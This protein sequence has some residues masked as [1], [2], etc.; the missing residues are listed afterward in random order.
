MIVGR[1][2]IHQEFSALNGAGVV[3]AL[4]IY[5]K[6]VAILSE[7]LPDDDQIAVGIERHVR[8]ALSAGGGSIYRQF[9]ADGRA[10]GVE[11]LGDDLELTIPD[12]GELTDIVHVHPG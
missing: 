7:A 4:A 6:A 1:G 5:A 3:V 2:R 9:A 12:Y 8:I 10:G 11:A